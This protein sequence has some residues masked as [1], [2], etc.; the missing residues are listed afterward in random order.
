[1]QQT[2]W[3]NVISVRLLSI[4]PIFENLPMLWR[5]AARVSPTCICRDAR[6][7]WTAENHVYNLL[8]RGFTSEPRGHAACPFDFYKCVGHQ[9][10]LLQPQFSSPSVITH[11]H[12]L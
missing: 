4:R 3:Q 5:P 1:M 8:H 12:T 6:R 2:D 10:W 11:P 7:N 9:F